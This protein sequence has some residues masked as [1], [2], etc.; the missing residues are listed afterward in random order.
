MN[1]SKYTKQ[2]EEEKISFSSNK[3][4]ARYIVGKMHNQVTD[5]ISDED[6]SKMSDK[7]YQKL[8]SGKKL[9]K[10]EEQFLK[11]TN[12]QL[13]IQYMRIRAK[14]EAMAEQL[15][16]AKTKQEVNN[17]ITASTA[18][19]SDKD[20][21]KEYAMAAMNKVAEEFKSTRAYQ[22]LPD[23]PAD[24]KKK[25][26]NENNNS[27]EKTDSGDEE[28]DLMNWSPLQEVIDAMPKFDMPV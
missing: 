11:E 26:T 5:K 20:P 12:P 4:I 27:E 19:V 10:K 7:I 22:K 9:S 16:H 21:V 13:Y 24:L 6:K 1:I 18:S 25:K 17:I 28:A 14:A 2:N 3:E 8:H 15:K 23:T